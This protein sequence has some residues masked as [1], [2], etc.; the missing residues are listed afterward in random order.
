M[1][2]IITILVLFV[3]VNIFAQAPQ[4]M[5]YQAIVRDGSDNLVVSTAVGMQ[6]SILQGSSSGTAVYVETHT[7]TSNANGLVTFEIGTGAVVSGDFTTIDWATGPYFIKIET[8]VTGGTA[9]TISGTSQLMSVPYAL[10]AANSSQVSGTA[11]NIQ[12]HD[13]TNWV[14][15]ASGTAG[16][17]LMS[18]GTA[19]PSW[20]SPM[21]CYADRDGDG[22]GDNFSRVIS[23]ENTCPTGFVSNGNDC[24]DYDASNTAQAPTVNATTDRNS[25][26]FT[27][28]WSSVN[29]ATAYY[30]DVATDASFSNFVA[31]YSNADMGTATLA[32][33]TG[34]DACTNY[35]YRV[36]AV[37]PCGTSAN[38]SVIESGTY[39]CMIFN[40]TGADQTFTVPLG[41]ANLSVELRGARGGQAWGQQGGQGG[42]VI[43]ALAVTSGATLT[44]I[45]GGAGGDDTTCFQS[46]GGGYGGG[47]GACDPE[48]WGGLGGGGGRSAIQFT[49]GTDVVTAGGG[50]GGDCN[51]SANGGSGGAEGIGSGGEGAKA[52]SCGWGPG[53]GGTSYTTNAAFSV[54]SSTVGGNYGHGSV[55]ISW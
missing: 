38:S 14:A 17:L 45:A 48:N 50:G 21:V 3:T 12:Y 54:T 9:Y 25:T 32:N 37:S 24:N 51:S 31:G 2:N 15:L 18:N 52:G 6:I 11:G 39:Q 20:V 29:N 47:G 53:A 33:I 35:Y 34:L 43:G 26:S 46:G 22:D 5:S 10:Y 49:A 40:Y 44:I 13:G 23:F 41:V 19:A 4:K 1:K 8:D 36:R 7:P 28:N 27:A 30:L 55:K 42:I 16:Q